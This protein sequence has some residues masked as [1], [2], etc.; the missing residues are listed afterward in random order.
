[1]FGLFGE[2]KTP[3]RRR[4]LT[5]VGELP[6]DSND[7]PRNRL[8]INALDNLSANDKGDKLST[9]SQSKLKKRDQ[10]FV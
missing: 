7:I 9:F 3:S 2:S 8:K 10:K 4:A 1:L 5:D 6:N